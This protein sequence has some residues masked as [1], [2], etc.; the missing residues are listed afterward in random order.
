[1][2][3]TPKQVQLVTTDST[4]NLVQRQCKAFLE[5]GFLPKSIQTPAQAIT[6]AWKGHELGI[7]PLQAFSSIAVINGRPCLSAELMLS[8][9]YQ[10]IPGALVLYTTPLDKQNT[11]ATVKARRK[12]G[13]EFQEF[14]FTMDD[15]KRAGL[16][17]PGTPWEKFPA[18]MLRSRAISAACRMVF[19][20]ALSGCVYTPDEVGGEPIDVEPT[21]EPAVKVLHGPVTK[22]EIVQA[23]DEHGAVEVR[24]PDKLPGIF[25]E[26]APQESF[27]L[28]AA[29][30]DI[31]SPGKNSKVN[32]WPKAKPG[33]EKDKCTEAQLRR[34]HVIG[35]ECG[36]T[37]EKIKQVVLD[38][39]GKES[40]TELTK[41]EIQELFLEMGK[42]NRV[43]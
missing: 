1:M 12:E 24:P 40:T 31:G 43:P 2:K 35:K 14:R 3:E 7:P 6:I 23:Y 10:K 19:P 33:W 22:K 39:Y 18:A 32:E 29:V 17:R 4:W 8:L 37:H 13:G 20:D 25:Q 21:P 15:A 26:E 27:N 34:L 16:V 9:V 30:K 42:V 38:K 28:D 5:S 36:W 41:A 11:E